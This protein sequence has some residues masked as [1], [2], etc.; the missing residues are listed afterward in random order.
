MPD[1]VSHYLI[2]VEIGRGGMGVVYSAH[3]TRLGR[4]VAIKMLP[5]EA[6]ADPDRHRRF[7]QEARAASA[8]NHPNIVTIHEI[9]ED[10]GTTFI[11]MELVDGTRLDSLIAQ[12][13]L[14]VAMALEYASQ[15]ASALDA[16]HASGIVHRD[17]K[18]AN[19]LITRDGRAKVLDF[20]LAKLVERGPA[21]ETMTGLETRPGLIMGTAAYMSPEQA[22]GRPV[23][24]RSD[25]FSLG[26][27]LYEMLSGR[28]PFAGHSDLGLITS[29]LRDQPPALRSVRPGVPPDVQAIVD[30][31]LAKNPDARYADAR[32][33][34]TALDA[35]QAKLTRPAEQAWRRPVVL[36]PVVLLLVAAGGFGA[37]QT[38][39]ARN[40][41]WARQEAIPEIERLQMTDVTLDAVRL[42]RQ[43][44]RYAPDEIARVRQ[45]WY[46]L[47]LQTEP[48]GASVEIRNYLDVN[49]TWEPLGVTPLNDIF[50]PFGF[51]HVRVTKTGYAPAEI[52]MA[53]AN[54]RLVTLTPEA[55]APA[56][57][58]LVTI[59]SGVYTVGI[60]R[61]VPLTDFWI[62]KF[63]VTNNDFKQFVDAGGYRDAKYWKEPFHDGAEVLAF[64]QA[65]AR[66]RDS[67][68]RP[69][70]SSWQL[71]SFPDGQ[72]DFPVSG[73]SWFEAAAYAEFAGKRLPTIY[74]WLRASN[75]EDL[76]S[77]ILRFG[78]FDS[79]G[80][81]KVGER[82][83][84][85]PWGTLDMAGNVKEWCANAANTDDMR[86]ILGGGWNE[87]SYRYSEPDARN[88]WE[89]ASTFGVRLIKDR[90]GVSGGTSAEAAAPIARTRLYGDPKTVVPVSDELFDVYRRFYTYDRT[91]LAA[92]SESV[93][94]S[95]PYWRLER[96]T[97]A[98]AYGQERVP[99]HLFLPK[100]ASPPYQTVVLFPSAYA[101]NASSSSTLDLSRFDFI[102]RSGRAL[103]YP[104]YQGTFERRQADRGLANARRD[105]QVQQ[106]KDFF[107]AV[108]YLETRPDI[109]MT[110]LGYYS[111]SMGAYFGPIPVSL[112][113]RIKVA[114]FA[115][116]GM[117]YNYPPE[118]QPANFAPRVTVPVLIINGRNDFQNPPESPAR[119]LELLGT[120]S[121][122]KK[123]VTLE[124]GHVPNDMLGVIRNVLDWY[125]TY[126]GPVK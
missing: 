21:K 110:R 42:A 92:K 44:E 26:A 107:R 116:A 73:I 10:N 101:L 121:N 24:A 49:G 23:T 80:A 2:D 97:F 90:A 46:P 98:A 19:I 119:L 1:H 16:A 66:L 55:S 123:L 53:A 43:A 68:G 4:S 96:V 39:Q 70:P 72:A 54:R 108:D 114:V 111:L 126:L 95:S 11:A 63:E 109:D 93:D 83:G 37:W 28:R 62:D 18:P 102:I 27:V 45:S 122:R 100:N 35:A 75:P 118:I 38:I 29:I 120:P 33:L 6:T 105:M 113:P 64:D 86:Y 20:G 50:V 47:N 65:M 94:D 115:S 8:L 17:I 25:I 22:E 76:F 71:G 48:V 106:A 69:G 36:I 3:D 117:R 74:H 124:G 31:C 7:V 79:K 34:K 85:G 14:P 104:I 78:N 51:F 59:P 77:D 81:V 91:P 112:E 41:R 82:P 32:A 15:V 56:R 103:L 57:M 52:T 88:A 84:F 125:D 58:V 87:P 30:R 89:R 12:G 99:A 61:T 9:D 67:T 60:A 13:P 5:P 40:L